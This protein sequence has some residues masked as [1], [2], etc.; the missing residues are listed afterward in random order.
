M[1]HVALSRP[2]SRRI[3]RSTH[4]SP[5]PYLRRRARAHGFRKRLVDVHGR[6]PNH[7]TSVEQFLQIRLPLHRL[8]IVCL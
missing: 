2:T 5:L 1:G 3:A 4:L 6:L 7:A 8:P